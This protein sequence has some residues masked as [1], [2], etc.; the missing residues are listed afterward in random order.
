LL[1]FA[2]FFSAHLHIT[3]EYAR[4]ENR[5]TEKMDGS[6]LAVLFAVL[7]SAFG[8]ENGIFIGVVL[9]FLITLYGAFIPFSL[10]ESGRCVILCVA[11]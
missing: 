6:F 4:E 10:S 1:A 2:S 5:K 7:I 3:R 8:I 9:L 11:V